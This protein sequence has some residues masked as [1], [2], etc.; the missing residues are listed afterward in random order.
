MNRIVWS[1]IAL[2]AFLLAAPEVAETRGPEI[3]AKRCASCHGAAKISGL[4]LRDRASALRGGSRGPAIVPGK[5]AESLLFAAI[6]GA[7]KLEMPPGK[8]KLTAG[9]I[10]ALRAWIASG[11]EWTSAPLAAQPSFWSF[12]KLVR[13]AV[14][15]GPS[16]PID[17]FV[18]RGLAAKGLTPAP[19]ADRATLIR[20]A[21]FDLIGLPP[22]P[23]KVR[24][25]VEDS[26]PE[27]WPNLID[28]LLASEHYGERWGRHWLDVVRY[29]D[30][31]GYETDILFKN[32]WR[33]R[34]YVIKSFNEGKPYDRFVQEQIAGDEMWPDN[35]DLSGTYDLPKQ[36][37]A[38][39]DARIGT[40][41]YTFGPEV[42]E[43][44]MDAEKLQYEKVTDWVDTTGSAF[45]GLTF[46]CARCHDHKFDPIT[47]RDYYRLA[48]VFAYSTETEVPVVH[49]M[50]IRDHGQHYPRVIAVSEA[51]TAYRLHEES[52]RKRLIAER[53][54][55][56]TPDEIAAYDAK[57]EARTPLQKEQ[58]EK[59][60]AAIR[61]IKLDKEM[62]A[63]EAEQSRRLLEAI[64]KAVL[65]VPER[66]AQRGLWDGLMDIPVASVLGHRDPALVPPTF[67]YSR[68]ELS[69]KR[70]KMQ[71]GLPAFLGGDVQFDDCS[72]RCV[73]LARKQLALWLT[74]PDH[75]LTA[76]VMANR[77][78]AWH[79]GRGLA[80]T[81]NDFGRQGQAPIL[82]ELLDWLASEFV[83]R[84][85]SVKA[86]HRLIM[87]SETYQRASAFKNEANLTVD[88]DNAYLWRFNRRR[89]E[90][91]VLWDAMHSAAGTLNL[92]MGGKPVA[93]PLSTDEASGMG[94]V[95]QWP[96]NAD[97]SE[98]SRRGVY[99]LVRRNMPYPMFEAF[100]N[101]INSV[102]CPQREVSSVAPQALWFLN[103]KVASEQA[104]RFAARLRKDFGNDPAALATG[105]WQLALGRA[106]SALEK[107]QAVDLIGKLSL[108]K[109][110]LSIFN[111]NEFA[112]VD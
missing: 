42:H 50:S 88:R 25:F 74:Q 63:A 94:S 15:A 80:A 110:C 97:P 10:E 12:R 77:V 21:Y 44:N 86:L 90:G 96:V 91:E 87:T 112:F 37:L 22:P 85:W 20:R 31:G 46:A 56:F 99:L 95:W 29:A 11:A 5:P 26:S 36:K 107:Q 27:A 51:R 57:E 101:P 38:N 72:G 48:A 13:P 3:L 4:D 54:K 47:Q 2:A 24:K 53:K 55:A 30:S 103:N 6:S 58:A 100:D 17:A 75:P 41:L 62:T 52:V 111:L 83:A 73:P 67:V 105:A 89:L 69:L 93:P 33:Y 43:S 70:D 7:G 16:H 45:L 68:G 92:R 66:D 35:L 23:G 1:S 59:V 84:K 9:E 14:P 32:A 8:E 18:Q 61:E 28:E 106:P 82:P 64:G 40:G 98:H 78:W 109:F 71:A 60:A 34:D 65:E 19:R 108:E 39:L 104:T 76:R 81:P 79:T 102:S 49:R